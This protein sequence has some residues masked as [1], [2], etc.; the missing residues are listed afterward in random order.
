MITCVG[1]MALD[2][3]FDCQSLSDPIGEQALGFRI[4]SQAF[5]ITTCA[6]RDR[7]AA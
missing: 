4:A 2:L 5:D 7:Q 6:C 1:G 3:A